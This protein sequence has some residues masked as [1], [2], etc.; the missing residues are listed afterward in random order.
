MENQAKEFLAYVFFTDIVS[1]SNRN[2]GSAETQIKKIEFLF[3]FIRKS[4]FFK[5]SGKNPIVSQ[6]GDGAAICYRTNIRLPIEL[7]FGIRA[8]SLL[9]L[10]A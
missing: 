2:L 3:D 10:P 7:A 5:E 9:F 6:T 8:G 4:N 1:L